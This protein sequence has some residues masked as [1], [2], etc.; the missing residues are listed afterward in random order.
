M[1]L[2]PQFF[3]AS[4]RAIAEKSLERGYLKYPAV[5]FIEEDETLA[6]V[7]IDNEI[8]YINGDKQIT[9]ITYQDNILSFYSSNNLIFSEEIGFSE[10][11][12]NELINQITEN[13][14][15]K[16]NLTEYTKREDV[17]SLLDDKVG[18]LEDKQT[19]ID[20]IKDLSY[21]VL[22]D[23]PIKNVGGSLT[24][25]VIISDLEDGIYKIKGQYAIGGNNTTIQS[26]FDDTYFIVTHEK[27]RTAITSICG[28]SIL[29]YFIEADGSYLFDRYITESWLENKDFI[30]SENIQEYVREVIGENINQVVSEI[31]DERIDIALENKIQGIEPIDIAHLFL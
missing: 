15:S 28:K 16:I 4:T 10:D 23:T 21:N 9:N 27:D 18:N 25:T 17:L 19:V 5:C 20:Y 22:K 12:V 26:S 29:L 3:A 7:T 30:T 31:L 24:N 13:I 14:S 11:Y 2:I 8:K 1:A 6:W